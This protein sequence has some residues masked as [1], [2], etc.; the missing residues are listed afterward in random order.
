LLIENDKQISSKSQ[1][2]NYKLRTRFEIYLANKIS[3]IQL[4]KMTY[5]DKNESFVGF[6]DACFIRIFFS[7]KKQ[8]LAQQPGEVMGLPFRDF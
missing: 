2:K 1:A 3:N 6:C 5:V 7:P 4:F 8:I